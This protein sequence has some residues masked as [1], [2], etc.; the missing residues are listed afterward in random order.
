[1]SHFSEIEGKYLGNLNKDDLEDFIKFKIFNNYYN[2]ENFFI[3][4]HEISRYFIDNFTN[5]IKDIIKEDNLEYLFLKIKKGLNDCL[6][7]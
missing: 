6:A 1:M 5:Y 4:E 3:G 7:L 2:S